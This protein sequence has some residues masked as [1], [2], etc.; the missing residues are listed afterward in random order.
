MARKREAVSG[1]RVYVTV[2]HDGTV[3]L[4][5]SVCTGP[6]Y[7]MKGPGSIHLTKGIS[8]E[9]LGKAVFRVLEECRTE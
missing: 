3:A 8:A 6:R 7:K 4:H 1:R 5:P 2:L 9:E